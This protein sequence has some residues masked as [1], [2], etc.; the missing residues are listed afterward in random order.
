MQKQMAQITKYSVCFSFIWCS[1]MAFLFLSVWTLTSKQG[2]VWVEP[3]DIDYWWL[4]HMIQAYVKLRGTGEQTSSTLDCRSQIK[5]SVVSQSSFKSR[6]SH[7][8]QYFKD[9]MVFAYTELR[10]AGMANILASPSLSLMYSILC[11]CI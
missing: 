2:V 6:S 3:Q 11:K 5:D 1:P 9:V 8:L 4:F 7:I 10:I